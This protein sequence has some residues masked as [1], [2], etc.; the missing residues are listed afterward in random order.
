MADFEAVI[1]KAVNTLDPNNSEKRQLVY[2]RA[3]SAVRQQLESFTPPPS[4]E[5]TLRYL[6]E[7]EGAI[8]IVETDSSKQDDPLAELARTMELDYTPPDLEDVLIGDTSDGDFPFADLQ[9]FATNNSPIPDEA[10]SP[11]ERLLGIESHS[12]PVDPAEYTKL[13]SQAIPDD[14]PGPSFEPGENGKL[15]L[16]RSGHAT[17]SDIERVASIRLALIEVVEELIGVSKGSNSHSQ[18]TKLATK[19]RNSLG[20]NEQ[21]LS[22]DLAYAYGL[23]LANF[24]AELTKGIAT[25]DFPEGSPEV[26]EALQSVETLHRTMIMDTVRGRELVSHVI[27][28]ENPTDAEAKR[29]SLTEVAEAV[30]QD[31]GLIE[32]DD[33]PEIVEIAK[34]FATGSNPGRSSQVATATM[35]NMLGSIAKPIAFGAAAAAT[36]I[37][38][39]ASWTGVV[40]GYNASLP[41]QNHAIQFFLAHAPALTRLSLLIGGDI[42]WVPSFLQWLKSRERK[43]Q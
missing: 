19:Y 25:G 38:G 42:S 12:K 39:N 20:E 1:R 21:E 32:K 13:V 43:E 40:S 41:F 18:V 37:I 33:A 31:D 4:E 8:Q 16:A 28:F 2:G 11:L 22:I 30:A 3:R 34:Q 7:L 5:V 10:L 17:K 14:L 6:E 35:S 36:G 24:R 23:R 9:I 26:E 27:E 15:K 29:D